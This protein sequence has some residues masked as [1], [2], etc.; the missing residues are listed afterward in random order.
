MDIKL[1]KII[2][3]IQKRTGIDIDVYD[4]L[5]HLLTSDRPIAVQRYRS[6][7][8]AD[9]TQ[10]IRTDE[11]GNAT[12]FLI[13]S[14]SSTY[15]GVI[16]G[17]DEVSKNYAYMV[18]ALIENTLGH[19]DDSLGR[20]DT[21]KAILLGECTR[22][23]VDKFVSKYSLP[24]VPLYVLCIA[25][26]KGRQG[27]VF[28]LLSQYSEN[29]HDTVVI[30]EDGL[31][32]YVGFNIGEAEY[33]SALDFA[34]HL[35]SSLYAETG[36]RVR[37]GVGSIA[38]SS[39][40]ISA[41]YQQAHSALKMG[42]LAKAKGN[43]HSYKE[44]IMVKMIE[45]IPRSS[46]AHYLDILLDPMAKEILYDDEMVE[47]A[48]EFLNNSLNISETSRLL[49]MHRNTLMYRLDKIERCMG[50]NIRRFSDAVT[51]RIILLLHR[52]LKG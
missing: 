9:F 8:L 15:I 21:L 45:D 7:K 10:G 40:E 52:H 5:G 31:A 6:F 12:Y 38:K 34:E 43:I 11:A 30:M 3:D 26:P 18:S 4:I 39:Y 2:K 44:Y 14:S 17:A 25:Y 27:E 42:Q 37:V 47:T 20:T 1:S 33:Q 28:S 46:L 36:L 50:L 32:A 35:S 23:Q 16:K 29:G 24:T 51:F 48:E 41:S 19:S 13:N 22:P 49:Y